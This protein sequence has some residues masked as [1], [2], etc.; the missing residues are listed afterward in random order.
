MTTTITAHEP[1]P[2]AA[3]PDADPPKPENPRR[4]RSAAEKPRIPGAKGKTV[5][6][7]CKRDVH[8]V[9]I[10]TKPGRF[11]KVALDPE[12]MTGAEYPRGSKRT[13]FRRVHAERCTVYQLENE[14]R[15]KRERWKRQS[16]G[17]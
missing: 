16:E 1:P 15:E 13:L 3:P 2:P 8:V 7:E 4:T 17:K 5:C 14:N 11:E 12:I 10:E 6:P 9:E